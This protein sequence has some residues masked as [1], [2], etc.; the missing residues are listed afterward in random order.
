[1]DNVDYIALHRKVVELRRVERKARL[2]GVPAGVQFLRDLLKDTVCDEDYIA[3]SGLLLVECAVFEMHDAEEILLRERIKRFP[4][5]P[6]PLIALSDFLVRQNDLEQARQVA[7]M[8]TAI[9]LAD[10]NFIRDAYNSL[11]RVAVKS[12]NYDLLEDTLLKLIEYRPGPGSQNVRYETDFLSELPADAVDSEILN[13]YL[14]ICAQ[15]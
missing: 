2:V 13:A 5:K 10:G 11:A 3:I 12:S 4:N 1:M 8:A 9:A 6:V 15:A 7:E 14:E